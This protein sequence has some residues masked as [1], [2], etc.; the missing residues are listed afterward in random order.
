MKIIKKTFD[1][2]RAAAHYHNLSDKIP[3]AYAFGRDVAKKVYK[4]DMHYGLE[5]G[6]VLKGEKN[7]VFSDYKMTLS[8]GNVWFCGMWEPHGWS[9]GRWP[10]QEV[11][12]VI[13]PP[14]LVSLRSEAVAQFNW[15]A[16]FTVPPSQRPQTD[17]TTQRAM[18]ALG[19]KILERFKKPDGRTCLWM[20]AYIMQAILLATEKWAEPELSNPTPAGFGE[21]LNQ[22]L[23]QFFDERKRMTVE[24]A[25]GIC[26]MNR[27]AFSR[28]FGRLMGLSFADFALRYRLSSA[29]SGLCRTDESVKS[30]SL[31]WGFAD[32]SH[33]D[34]MFVKYY[35][36]TPHEY[37]QKSAP[38][39]I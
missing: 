18:L 11:N 15:L 32:T 27:K 7:I 31:R 9:E 17:G 35:G 22:V 33:F 13:W 39:N 38:A 3:F 37:R 20:K 14:A 25:A 28:M 8:A 12:F 5:F 34:R 23:K 24:K 10:C 16:P 21:R 4:Y 19:L 2:S 29:A 36:C 30:I 6:I 26:S 1:L